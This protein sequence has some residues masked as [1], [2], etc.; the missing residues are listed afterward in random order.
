METTF[1]V[2]Q[3]PEKFLPGLGARVWNLLI[4]QQQPFWAPKG[5]IVYGVLPNWSGPK[6][7]ER[8]TMKE[9]LDYAKS[10]S[11]K[12]PRLLA[13]AGFDLYQEYDL[14]TLLPIG[15]SLAAMD[16]MSLCGRN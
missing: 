15:D 6:F 13:G 5:T 1:F 3:S 10:I 8:S 7:A 11:G 4:I 16:L 12:K 9:A 14:D 2:R